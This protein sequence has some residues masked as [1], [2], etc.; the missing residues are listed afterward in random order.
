MKIVYQSKTN[1]SNNL[2]LYRH[3]T[4]LIIHK[5]TKKCLTL[6]EK[7]DILIEYRKDTE[8]DDNVRFHN[9]LSLAASMNVMLQP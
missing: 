8:K 2:L 1:Y 7:K 4:Q 6:A 3:T 5:T 9:K